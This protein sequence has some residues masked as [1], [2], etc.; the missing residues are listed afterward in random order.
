MILFSS[1][2]VSVLLTWEHREDLAALVMHSS[3]VNAGVK[4]LET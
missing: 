2:S 4:M 1:D 3:L